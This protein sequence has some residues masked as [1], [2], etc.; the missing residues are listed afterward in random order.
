MAVFGILILFKSI[1]LIVGIILIGNMVFVLKV[2]EMPRIQ[3]SKY[4]LIILS[5]FSFFILIQFI[6]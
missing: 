5:C 4:I 6:L 3:L 1:A 2:S